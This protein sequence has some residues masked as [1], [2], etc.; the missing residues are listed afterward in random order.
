MKRFS[1]STSSASLAGRA[2]RAYN[3][4]LDFDSALDKILRKHEEQYI[5]PPHFNKSTPAVEGRSGEH[6]AFGKQ[7]KSFCVIVRIDGA[8]RLPETVA[9][10][11]HAKVAE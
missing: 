4:F 8:R 1:Q 11:K 10:S 6:G 2:R 7:Y 9:A 5:I 3:R